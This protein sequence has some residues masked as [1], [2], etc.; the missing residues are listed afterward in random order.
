MNSILLKRTPQNIKYKCTKISQKQSD[1][2]FIF[3]HIKLIKNYITFQNNFYIYLQASHW[4]VIHIIIIILFSSQLAL[5]RDIQVQ[6]PLPS[7]FRL[8]SKKIFFFFKICFQIPNKSTR[9]IL[10]QLE[11]DALKLLFNPAF[12]QLSSIAK[13]PYSTSSSLGQETSLSSLPN[14]FSFKAPL[15]HPRH[16]HPNPNLLALH[17]PA[18]LQD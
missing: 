10:D 15:H 18:Y 12:S 13:P 1:L 2:L 6:I 8:H 16:Y 7:L 4:N 3:F 5:I 11:V 14:A 9:K 17:L